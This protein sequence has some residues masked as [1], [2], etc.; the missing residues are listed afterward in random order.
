MKRKQEPR[1]RPLFELSDVLNTDVDSTER[2]EVRGHR[3][4][5]VPRPD[6]EAEAARLVEGYGG[7]RRQTRRDLRARAAAAV[8]VLQKMARQIVV[9]QDLRLDPEE[10]RILNELLRRQPYWQAGCDPEPDA[11]GSAPLTVVELQ[12]PPRT[13]F[14][15]ILC[16]S[17]RQLVELTLP[18]IK[19]RLVRC[20]APVLPADP[21]VSYS[22][23]VLVHPMLSNFSNLAGDTN[24]R[25][26]RLLIE[27]ML[28][29]REDL[30]FYVMTPRGWRGERGYVDDP[31][32]TFIPVHFDT[33]RR[34]SARQFDV[35]DLGPFHNG[36]TYDVDL[37]WCNVPELATAYSVYFAHGRT[38]R[39]VPVV[40]H[41][42]I[43]TL[44]KYP[45]DRIQRIAGMIPDHA[46]FHGRYQQ[47]NT[48][49]FAMERLGAKAADT[50]QRRSIAIP[51]I[52]LDLDYL[53][54]HGGKPKYEKPTIAWP[55]KLDEQKGYKQAFPELERL[56]STG[57][58]F[59]LCVLNPGKNA[60]SRALKLPFAFEGEGRPHSAYLD[61]L[62][63]CHVVLAWPR[64]DTWSN[65]SMEAAF[66]GL[67][68]VAPRKL[69][70]PEQMPE[71]YPYLFETAHEMRAML[72]LLLEDAD[73]CEKW[74][75]VLARH[76]REHHDVNVIA[77]QLLDCWG[78]VRGPRECNTRVGDEKRRQILD[79]A[80]SAGRSPISMQQFNAAH[81]QL[82]GSTM[83]DGM[84]G[85][86]SEARRVLLDAGWRDDH[87]SPRVLFRKPEAD[88]PLDAEAKE[89]V[90]THDWR[91]ARARRRPTARGPTA[92][93]T[94]DP[95]QR[96][97]PER[98]DASDA[99]GCRRG[100]RTARLRR[101]HHGSARPRAGGRLR[102]HRRRAP[103]GGGPPPGHAADPR[104]RGGPVGGRGPD[105]DRVLERPPRGARSDQVPRAV[106]RASQAPRRRAPA[107]Q[108]GPNE[109]QAEELPPEG[110][111]GTAR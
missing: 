76:V 72:Q 9:G 53:G 85:S 18:G 109:G 110:H 42:F 30:H 104:R 95:H 64:E 40:S 67:P 21:E 73:E 58:R 2:R 47:A 55:H 100:H 12:K 103:T 29:Q 70:F 15:E 61:C 27:A 1:I 36:L 87:T 14:R 74:G 32:L 13:P 101:R 10:T 39:Y 90:A 34:I 91:H 16:R 68:V 102:R 25:V 108:D 81:R 79:A 17:A 106:E 6:P 31:R 8:R 94:T 59:A 46:V 7:R 88:A 63:R 5:V 69:C 93:H 56:W 11:D 83:M 92:G 50:L 98:D 89:E 57:V 24:W 111:Q 62:S 86:P 28:R 60:L 48:V 49:A 22:M 26:N 99:G 107:G 65:A 51:T 77:G 23:R 37:V 84:F 80:E 78:H 35:R 41:P 97:Q 38:Q 19:E 3:T 71:G 4:V 96:L 44:S 52:A 82:H 43:G 66:Y 105:T 45:E 54:Q 20:P 75:A 33:S